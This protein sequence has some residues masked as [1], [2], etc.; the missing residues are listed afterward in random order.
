MAFMTI[1]LLSGFMTLAAYV[2]LIVMAIG[3]FVLQFILS[4][5]KNPWAGLILPGLVSA[6]VLYLCV[7]SGDFLG[8]LVV[9]KYFVLA[10]VLYVLI[11]LFCRIRRKK[12]MLNAPEDKEQG[13]KKKYTY[14]YRE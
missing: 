8:G 7:L 10:V 14:Y 4:K 5:L 1:V 6:F 3:S 12:Q 13:K 11:Y 2:M 9:M